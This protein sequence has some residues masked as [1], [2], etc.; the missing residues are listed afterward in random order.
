MDN[1]RDDGV[2]IISSPATVQYQP[3][4]L[5]TKTS[6]TVQT[7]GVITVHVTWI[8]TAS[9]RKLQYRIQQTLTHSFRV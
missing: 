9:A 1:N 4:L 3:A 2:L 5:L 7:S 6:L 8:N